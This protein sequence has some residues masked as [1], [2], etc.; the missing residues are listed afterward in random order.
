[1]HLGEEQSSHVFAMSAAYGTGAMASDNALIIQRNFHAVRSRLGAKTFGF[2]QLALY[3]GIKD[4]PVAIVV[5]SP[6]E[7]TVI[8]PLVDSVLV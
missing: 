5:L 3:P 6:L 1:M 7:R 2:Q 4:V 8:N